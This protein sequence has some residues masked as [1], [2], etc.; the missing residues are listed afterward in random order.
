MRLLTGRLAGLVGL[1]CL[2]AV[3]AGPVRAADGPIQGGSGGASGPLAADLNAAGNDLLNVG[4]LDFSILHCDGLLNGGKL[5]T[6]AAGK[7]ICEDD[8]SGSDGDGDSGDLIISDPPNF[9]GRVS[10]PT[11]VVNGATTCKAIVTQLSGT[12]LTD[13]YLELAGTYVAATPQ[14]AS[15]GFK[16]VKATFLPLCNGSAFECGDNFTTFTEQMRT[17]AAIY[18]PWTSAPQRPAIE[19]VGYIYNVDPR[20][21]FKLKGG[22][23]T[24]DFSAGPD[25]QVVGNGSGA[26]T[27]ITGTSTITVGTDPGLL[28]CTS[29]GFCAT[30]NCYDGDELLRPGDAIR[31]TS[32]GSWESNTA[33]VH[34]VTK[35]TDDDHIRIT[36]PALSD[37]SG[38]IE[39]A[40]GK[41]WEIDNLS[42]TGSEGNK[43]DNWGG[44]EMIGAQNANIQCFGTCASVNP[45][46]SPARTSPTYRTIPLAGLVT[47]QNTS[48]IGMNIQGFNGKWDRAV[49][50]T[51]GNAGDSSDVYGEFVGGVCNSPTA[52]D[53]KYMRTAADDT[54]KTDDG[55]N[56]M[57]LVMAPNI[58]INPRSSCG[59]GI[60][61][62][63]AG[64]NGGN[65]TV[66]ARLM[67]N[68][69]E[70][71]YAPNGM[72]NVVFNVASREQGMFC[73]DVGQPTCEAEAA[74]HPFIDIGPWEWPDALEPAH[75]VFNL[76]KVFFYL[77]KQPLLKIS[78]SEPVR[79]DLD[80]TVR[81]T[82][83]LLDVS[84][85][86]IEINGQV[87]CSS[88]TLNACSVPA[89]GKYG[90]LQVTDVAGDVIY[91][92]R[93]LATLSGKLPLA[94]LT[95]DDVNTGRCLLS[96]GAGGAANYQ[97][98]PGGV[99][100]LATI[101]TALVGNN[102]IGTVQL[103]FD[104]I[105][106]LN[107]YVAGTSSGLVLNGGDAFVG[108]VTIQTGT[109]TG[110]FRVVAAAGDGFTILP[111]SSIGS[112]EIVDGSVGTAEIATGGVATAEILDGTI[113]TADI[114]ANQITGSLI[115]D[116][117]VGASEI[118][119]GSVGVAE[120]ATDGVGS[121]E[122]AADAVTASEIAAN[123]VGA[124]EIA[125]DAVG[126][127][128]IATDAVGSAEILTDAVGSDEIA[129]SAVT[130]SEIAT[131][132]VGASEIAGDA[133]GASEIAAG[134]VGNGEL[135]TDAVSTIKILDGAVTVAKV[136]AA[137]TADDTTFLRG[138][139][140]WAEPP[141]A[142]G[143]TTE[144]ASNLGDG[145]ANYST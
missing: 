70:L 32:A 30:G 11:G 2:F 39:G 143:G 141:G 101:T 63:G 114:G 92:G 118:L 45:W 120:I 82:N 87:K 145:L 88:S 128:E 61:V 79:V 73:G 95:D 89:T 90:N 102:S 85:N 12:V 93:S 33:R 14:T 91:D 31:L 43:V 49:V 103:T 99:P 56:T 36:P 76:N 108:R 75:Y 58:N 135:A 17:L 136:G 83:D 27:T 98:C 107:P 100:D 44:V 18:D 37:Y 19:F 131:D 94:S 52:E 139:G 140:E 38:S 60:Y 67:E 121:A 115:G 3:L 138:D 126:A 65:M 105:G 10:C 26:T 113:A 48:S 130:A 119:D 84:S 111:D 125:A 42:G 28:T 55:R 59:G 69:G 134:A 124:S 13:G 127:S 110:E 97:V 71:F 25:F 66:D 117:Q 21:P 137:G 123:A 50:F 22:K 15:N 54:T 6:N 1:V 112:L 122:I 80:V 144:T 46:S 64:P 40:A 129:A 72:Q 4:D 35:I 132:A 8:E 68:T 142:S 104:P 78:D 34:Y 51:M 23:W 81:E 53:G 24:L 16:L 106:S 96:G 116:D 74:R 109:S 62:Y 5:T 9:V 47:R 57:F 29:C 7:M 86:A 20:R 133:V 41:I 77:H